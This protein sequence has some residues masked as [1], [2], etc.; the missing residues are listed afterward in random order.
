MLDG[1][2]MSNPVVDDTHTHTATADIYWQISVRVTLQFVFVSF[3][4]L[5]ITKCVLCRRRR[6]LGELFP[7]PELPGILGKL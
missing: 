2:S 5:K 7:M 4:D 6:R 3:A 1:L